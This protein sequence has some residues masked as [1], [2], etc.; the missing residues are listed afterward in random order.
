MLSL[1]Q[2]ASRP[3]PST[4][5][6]SGVRRWALDDGYYLL[7]KAHTSFTPGKTIFSRVTEGGEND[8]PRLLQ[9]IKRQASLKRPALPCL[10]SIS[11]APYL[12]GGQSRRNGASDHACAPQ[13]ASYDA[14]AAL[15]PR[16]GGTGP[17]G[18]S[19]PRTNTLISSAPP[20]RETW[21]L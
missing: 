15:P 4:L 2:N 12:C 10:K 6:Q 1:D 7:T 16:L 19:C 17:H 8:P 5:T 13:D 11:A 21:D 9:S 20:G 14:R 18:T 3:T